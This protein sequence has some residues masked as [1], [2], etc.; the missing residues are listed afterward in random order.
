M[1]DSALLSL[2][3]SLPL[4]AVL[5]SSAAGCGPKGGEQAPQTS[6]GAEPD[7]FAG[8]ESGA[9]RPAA[10]ARPVSNDDA[11]SDGV[12]DEADACPEVAGVANVSS[13]QLHGCP[14]TASA[15][16]KRP[17]KPDRSEKKAATMVGLRDASRNHAVVYVNLTDKPE[18][19]LQQTDSLLTITL[20]GVTVPRK[21]NKNP[22][23]ATH[24][25][26]IVSSARLASHNG[27]TRLLIELRQA[28]EA[29][30]NLLDETGASTLEV[31]V[32]AKAEGEAR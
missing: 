4:L 12:F 20:K 30:I 13:P 29:R 15:S 8:Y 9:S 6:E 24:F 19:K 28:A 23:V 26:S 16:Q 18:L 22:L 14:V 5:C 27:D 11:D 31:D 7:A 2:R 3:F 17:S 32:T 21:N 1:T 25:D 10:S